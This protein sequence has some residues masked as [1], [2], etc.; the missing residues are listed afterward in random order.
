MAD[1]VF[2]RALGYERAWLELPGAG[3]GLLFV[4]L[5]AL[6]LQEDED[7]ADHATLAAIVAAN[8]EAT[9]TN[10]N[11][12]FVSAGITTGPVNTGTNEVDCVIQ[13]LLWA[14]A[15]GAAN[16][17]VGKLIVCYAPTNAT[18]DSGIFPMSAHDAVF[19]TDGTGIAVQWDPAGFLNLAG[20][21]TTS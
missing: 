1:F 9:F 11:R 20:L 5:K 2:G 15:G 12:L 17:D 3:D 16:N 6:G 19:T 7:L 18:P 4:L 14:D 10:Y 13:N 21:F 8:T